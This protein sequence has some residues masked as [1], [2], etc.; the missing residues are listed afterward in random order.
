MTSKINLNKQ[1]A[2]K[3]K[4]FFAELDLVDRMPGELWKEVEDI[5]IEQGKK[6]HP[7]SKQKDEGLG[8]G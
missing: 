3:E 4:L 5:L 8:K 6:Q 7:K 1:C 2:I